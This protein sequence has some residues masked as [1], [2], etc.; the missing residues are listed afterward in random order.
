MQNIIDFLGD[1]LVWS[2]YVGI[3]M[4]IAAWGGARFFAGV[5]ARH[6]GNDRS[7]IERGTTRAWRLVI[8]LHL[9]IMT[10]WAIGLSVHTLPSVPDWPYILWYL[11]SYMPF[12]IVDV[13]ILISLSSHSKASKKAEQE[14]RKD[15]EKKIEN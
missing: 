7:A 15:S 6:I 4:Y 14:Q 8:I 1:S 5:F 2:V 12:L 11:V 13:C 9:L 3:L 10:G